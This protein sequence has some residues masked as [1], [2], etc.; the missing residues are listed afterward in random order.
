MVRGILIAAVVAFAPLSA[1]AAEAKHPHPQEWS[2]SGPFGTFDQGAVQRGFQVY[3][4][5]C[6]SCHTMNNLT[7]RHLGE[8][9]G[10]FVASGKRNAASGAWE[11][12]HLGPPHHGARLVPAPENPYVRAIAESYE[13]TEIDPTTGQEITRKARPAD[14]FVSPYTNPYQAK[15]VHGVAPPDL[16]VITKARHDGANYVH[17]ILMGYTQAPEGEVAP[18]GAT[19]LHYNPYFAG[20]WISMAPQLTPDRVSY[21]DGTAATQ[22]Q[23][24]RDVVT[25]LAWASEPKQVERKKT[26][27]MVIIYLTIL[28]GLL[29]AAYR[30]VW[31]DVKH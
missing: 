10:P 18:G 19:N 14:R 8:K 9:G 4:E 29:Y 21:S 31:R 17:A 30:Q 11:D 15:A 16:S 27:L 25:F 12:V 7:Y 5:V 24:A 28:A 2:F 3:K 23:M 26:G 13:I 22:E 6:A 1:Q 20:G